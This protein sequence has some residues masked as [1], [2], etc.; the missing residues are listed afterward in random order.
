M[1][2]CG[3]IRAKGTGGGSWGGEPLTP[4]LSHIL[5]SALFVANIQPERWRYG[6]ESILHIIFNSIE[7]WN[8]NIKRN[9]DSE[10]VI[11]HASLTSVSHTTLD[12]KGHLF[13][14]INL[15]TQTQFWKKSEYCANKILPMFYLS[16]N[17]VHKGHIEYM[18]EAL[19]MLIYVT[20][21]PFIPLFLP[22]FSFFIAILSYISARNQ[23]G[24]IS[25]I[26][27]MNCQKMKRFFQTNFSPF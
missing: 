14:Q 26:W 21:G 6:V 22:T 1:N 25:I 20:T 7:N 18:V 5:I 11:I 15:P 9:P 4:S 13:I 3:S 24:N 19:C 2:D 17:C 8:L 23:L 12:L 10:E 27:D 16:A